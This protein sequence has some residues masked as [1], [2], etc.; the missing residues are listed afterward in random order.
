M[1]IMSTLDAA[2]HGVPNAN[3]LGMSDIPPDVLILILSSLHGQDVARCIAVSDPVEPP[4]TF[5]THSYQVCHAFADVIRSDLSLQYRIELAQN[6][7]VD[8]E[9]STALLVSEKLQRIRQYSS[10]FKSGAFQHEDLTAHPDYVLRQA[11]LGWPRDVIFP[12]GPSGAV[13]R[14]SYQEDSPLHISLFV[15]GSAQAGIPS[16]RSL[17]SVRE[18]VKPEVNAK[19][20]AMDDAQDLFVVV[21]MTR[22][23]DRWETYG[24]CG[25][26]GVSCVQSVISAY[27]YIISYLGRTLS[28]PS[29]CVSIRCPA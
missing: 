4:E 8:G 23:S 27:A 26:L 15:P 10:N 29:T 16:S 1:A 12:E 7:M 24:R 22:I 14:K 6:G 20:W 5:L 3:H 18:A 19:L 2:P 9:S 28:P 21:E 13:F 17:F 25:A 11:E